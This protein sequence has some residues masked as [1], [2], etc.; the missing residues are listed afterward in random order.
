MENENGQPEVCMEGIC[1]DQQSFPYFEIWK[2]W[3]KNE[4]LLQFESSERM[5]IFSL[6]FDDDMED[7]CK[8][9]C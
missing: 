8:N 7:N 9:P 6:H 2:G 4:M 5:S 3:P 1:A